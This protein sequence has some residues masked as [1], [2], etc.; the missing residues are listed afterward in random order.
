MAN[1]MRNCKDDS[2]PEDN[3]LY[4]PPMGFTPKIWDPKI[5]EVDG[6]VKI[7]PKEHALP[8]PAK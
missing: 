2:I 8:N 6:S 7:Y 4:T 3:D 1:L 5:K